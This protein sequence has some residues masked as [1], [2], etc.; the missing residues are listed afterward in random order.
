VVSRNWEHTIAFM[1][2]P[3]GECSFQSAKPPMCYRPKSQPASGVS[4]LD[5][6]GIVS[7]YLP[8][9]ECRAED[10]VSPAEQGTL[11][12]RPRRKA[13]NPAASSPMSSP[14]TH[15]G[16]DA[17]K[18]FTLIELLTVIAIIG[19]LAG[20][21][22]GVIQ[23]V[24]SQ[25]KANRASAELASLSAAL[26]EY[27]RYHGDYPWVGN[28]ANPNGLDPTTFSPSSGDRAY[29][30][31]RALGGR[32]APK[33]LPS[34]NNGILQR[35]INLTG[36]M[37]DK[38]ARSFVDFSLFTLER[39]EVGDDP[40]GNPLPEPI[41]SVAQPDPDFVNAFLDPWG[42][43]Y[44]YYYRNQT[45]AANWKRPTY[46]LMSAGPDGQAT[47][48]TAAGVLPAATGIDADN[49]YAMP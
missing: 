41:A 12:L 35:Q 34:N 20:I 36:S 27:K 43:R 29:N 47:P 49:I 38:Y 1:P 11:P 46:I 10:R 21:T 5:R 23:G 18:A 3:S 45:A 37:Q 17:C 44:L 19:V 40:G 28:D 26:E 30:L 7:G 2:E 32:L 31:F 6:P 16:R 4:S 48:P 8:S 22:F 9:S 13:F 42:K 33:R 24:G 14:L 39:N 25:A 15:G